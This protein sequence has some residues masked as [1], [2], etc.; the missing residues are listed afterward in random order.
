MKKAKEKERVYIINGARSYIGIENSM[1]RHI[2]V[3][4]LGAAVLAKVAACC[5]QEA[6][7][8][9]MA[10]NAVGAGGNPARLTALEAGLPQWI[11]AITLDAQCSSGL[12]SIAAAAAKISSGQADLIVAGGMESSSTAPRRGYHENHPDYQ[13]AGGAHAW[14]RAAKFSPGA[15][16][17]SAMLDGAER[18][19]AAHEITRT[20]LDPWVLRSH[21]LA[22]KTREAGILEDILIEVKEGCNFDEGIRDRMSQRLLDRVP[23]VVQNGSVTTAAN[24]C[25]TNDGAAFLSLCS[26]SYL[27]KHDRKPWAEFLDAVSVGGDPQKSPE[28]MIPAIRKLLMRNGLD[29]TDIDIFECNEAFA[30]IDELFADAYPGAVARYNVLGGALAYGHPYGATGGILVLHALKALEQNAG[31]LAVCGIAA[32]GGMGTAVLLRRCAS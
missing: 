29:E 16:L 3:E 14:Y 24:A 26:E 10:G 19:A 21:Q 4:K 12:E 9:I 32:A 20:Q 28:A 31:Q 18:T 1:Y 7:D 27:R 30:V 17:E 2:P 5:P 13:A 22:V 8:L 11:P 15:H 6:I 23:C 25:L